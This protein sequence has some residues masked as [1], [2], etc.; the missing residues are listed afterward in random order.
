MT[1]ADGMKRE[2]VRA[3]QSILRPLVRQLIAHG[4]TFPA[5]SRL[6]KEVYIDVGTTHFALPF[7]K[8]TDSRIALVTGITRKEIGQIRRGQATPLTEAVHQTYGVATR[9]IGRWVA[10]KR[11][12]EADGAPREL[13]Y[14]ESPGA[15]SFVGLVD[16]VGGDIPPR[17][18]L[19]EL[20]RV[21]AVAL[22]PRGSVRLLE[23]AY[24]PAQ[25]IEEKLAILGADAAELIGAITHN[26][27]Q[28]SEQAF[29]QRKVY[30][31]NIGALALPELRQQVRNAGSAFVQE[32]NQILASY[33][34]DRNPKAPGG[35]RKRAVV[36]VFYFEDDYEPQGPEP[37]SGRDEP[38]EPS[39]ESR[40]ERK[41]PRPR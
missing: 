20:I 34:R 15:P 8:Q 19:D 17:A 16:E 33:D 27:E 9:V 3:V 2:L 21:G 29:L 25:G 36:G 37:V 1:P 24:I 5:F 12:L 23:R 4:I 30:Y 39:R 13:A 18:V 38:E 6:A 26:I 11:Y 32:V 22:S 28:P 41:R 7:K 35:I 40:R 14:D 10:E 31:D